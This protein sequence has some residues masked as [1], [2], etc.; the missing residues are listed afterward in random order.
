MPRALAQRSTST[1]PALETWQTCSREPVCRA[2]I[3][4]RAMMLSSATEGQ[5]GSPSRPDS[6]PSWAQQLASAS[7]G[8]WACWASTASNGLRYSSARRISRASLT[9]CPSSLN[10]RDRGGRAGHVGDLGELL[11]G[12]PAR[13]RA[14]RPDVDQAGQLAQPGHLL[15]HLGGVGDRIGVGHRVH[16]GEPAEGS[17]GRTGG[18]RLGVLAAGLA[19]VG[20]QVDQ[21]GQQHRAVGLD[22]LRAV[23]RGSSVDPTSAMTPSASSTSAGGAAQ[24]PDPAQQHRDRLAGPGHAGAAPAG[25]AA[26][27]APVRPRRRRPAGGRAPPSGPPPRPGPGPA[28]A[29]GRCRPATEEIS[30]PRFIGP[31][32]S[33]GACSGSSSSRAGLSP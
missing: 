22:Q 10:T 6:S 13:D 15:D 26:R 9:Q 7:R 14:D 11:A 8:S 21:A 30:R 2:S 24:R 28:P 3:T 27:S 20:V 1:L 5:P 17:R 33:T 23:R 12:Q 18:D 29:T 31:G 19:Q 4:S 32:C 25:A 16:R